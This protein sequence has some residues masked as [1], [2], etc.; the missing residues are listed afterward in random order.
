M[1]RIVVYSL[2]HSSTFC[3]TITLSMKKLYKLG[4]IC[5]IL[6]PFKKQ[7]DEGVGK[8]SSNKIVKESDACF[9]TNRGGQV[10]PLQHS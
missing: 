10:N 6:L 2:M 8:W 3:R 4:Q 1:I 5:D 7:G 9:E